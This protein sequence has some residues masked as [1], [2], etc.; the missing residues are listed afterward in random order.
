MKAEA[1]H[2]ITVDFGI[3]NK[4]VDNWIGRE[5]HIKLLDYRPW[6]EMFAVRYQDYFK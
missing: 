2:R 4:S 1:V 3:E 6:L 5:A